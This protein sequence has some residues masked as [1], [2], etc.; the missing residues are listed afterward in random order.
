M[1]PPNQDLDPCAI[2]QIS[3]A[4]KTIATG[5]SLYQLCPRC[6]E[7]KASGTAMSL[8]SQ[9]LGPEKRAKLSGWV[10]EQYMA[11]A[12]PMLTDEIMKQIL[13]RPLPSFAERAERLLLEAVRGQKE[14]GEDFNLFDPRFLAASYSKNT[15]EVV[16]LQKF[17][18]EEGMLEATALGGVAEVLPAGYIH[19]DEITRK[20]TKG[21]QGFIAMWFSSDLDIALSEG[22]E[23]GIRSAGYDPLRVDGVEHNNKIDDEIIAQIKVSRFVIADFTGHRG[24][25][26]F[27]AGYAF[28]LGIPVIWTCKKD[29]IGDLHFD[30]RQFNCIDWDTPTELADRLEKRIKAVIGVGP[31]KVLE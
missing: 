3:K 19:Y 23:P 24:G 12:V 6:G 26:Y 4:E 14:M 28:G 17:L 29:Q 20:T 21:S 30:I 27:E 13:A 8:L 31:N 16:F 18:K 2:C 1:T 7:Y 10:R 11:G 25:V 5:D 15:D 9:G 22:F